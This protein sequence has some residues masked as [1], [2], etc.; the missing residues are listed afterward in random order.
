MFRRFGGGGA[1]ALIHLVLILTL[2]EA[3]I[4]ILPLLHPS[5]LLRSLWHDGQTRASVAARLPWAVELPLALLQLTMFV[6]KNKHLVYHL[7]KGR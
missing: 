6:L 2:V 5:T 3:L 4:L 7:L 1:G